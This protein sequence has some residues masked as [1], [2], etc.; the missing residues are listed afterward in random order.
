M[1]YNER[2]IPEVFAELLVNKLPLV[3]ELD[4]RRLREK[5]LEAR[6]SFYE[7]SKNYEGLDMLEREYGYSLDRTDKQRKALRAF[8]ENGDKEKVE[9]ITEL[10]ALFGMSNAADILYQLYPEYR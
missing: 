2:Q 10:I 4:Q 5:T 6:A 7:E 3:N 8:L 9:Q 1:Y